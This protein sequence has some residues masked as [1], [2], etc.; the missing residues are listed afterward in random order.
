MK[1]PR[2]LRGRDLAQALCR[3]WD[4]REVNREGSHIILQTETPSHQR[5]SVPDHNPVRVGTLSNIL[6]LVAAHKGVA[7]EGILQSL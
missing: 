6:R 5:I 4:Y 7:R 1:L 3:R 2:D